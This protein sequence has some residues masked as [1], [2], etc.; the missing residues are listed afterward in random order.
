MEFALS[1]IARSLFTQ[2]NYET[3]PPARTDLQY[4]GDL[5]YAYLQRGPDDSGLNWWA[6]QAA[7]SRVNVCNAF[8]ASSEF[9]TLVAN[10]CGTAAS[11]NERA[12]HFVNNFYL[13]A[14][15][16]NATSTQLQ[17]QRDALNTAAG[18]GLSQVQAQ[19]ETFGRSLFTAQVNDSSL[20]NTQ[21]VTNLYEAF[22]Q[23][24]PD[25]GGLSFWAG[26]AS[27]GSGR[28]NVLNA[29][30]TCGAFRDLA[31]TLYREANWVVADHLG[32]PRMIVNKSGSLSSV[33]RHDYLPFGEE[34]YAGMGGRTA[35]PQGYSGDSMRQKFTSKE[36]DIET[37]L[38]YFGARY[39][40]S[41][42]GRFT[43]VD[44]DNAEAAMDFSDPQS[45]NGYAYVKNN[46]CSNTDPDGRCFCPFQRLNNLFSGYGPYS[47]EQLQQ[48][49]N[50]WRQYLRDKQK[51]YGTLVYTDPNT[52]QQSIVN[53]ET[54]S[55]AMVFHYAASFREAEYYH[56]LEQY[57][58]QQV[59][60]MPQLAAPVIN[61]GSQQLQKKFKHAGDFGVK[62][63]YNP[64]NAARYQ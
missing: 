7:S 54:I 18:Q 4:V 12:E 19:A 5:Y 16:V 30:A 11:D 9:Q 43:T 41:A 20:S 37:G 50:Q 44:P 1:T 47:N 34:L 59:N 49:E 51:E 17:Q 2:T 29:F 35:S 6:G 21:Y 40:A 15:G 61:F 26:Q 56:R 32:T 39:Y 62:G 31:G 42:Q 13:G 63:S 25:A 36:R 23:R 27:V 33:K 10:L 57:T 14:Y 28:Q 46:P 60:Q 8:E 55:R 3:A 64:A 24:G 58:P 52:G 22:L 48:K 53:P 38:D 45:W